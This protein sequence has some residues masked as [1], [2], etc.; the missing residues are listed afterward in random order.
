MVS[1]DL[2][3]QL[4]DAGIDVGDRLPLTFLTAED[5]RSFDTGFGRPGGPTVDAQ[6]VGTYQMAGGSEGVPPVVTSRAFVAAHPDALVATQVVLVRLSD[7]ADGVPELRR[8]VD[9]LSDE[10][11]VAAGAEEFDTFQIEVPG[12]AR[13]EIQTTARVL[14][15]G[16]AAFAGVAA[17]RR[18]VPAGAGLQPLSRRRQRGR[19]RARGPRRDLRSDPRR[20]PGRRCARRAVGRCA[21]GRRRCGHRRPRTARVHARPRAPPRAGAERRRGRRRRPADHGRGARPWWPSPWP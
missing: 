18:A 5:Y 1:E 17:A 21:G 14:G 11:A 6:L 7:G 3:G 20:P 13:S 8:Q 9:A 4:L 15:A 10:F 16:L 19:G 2:A 12:E